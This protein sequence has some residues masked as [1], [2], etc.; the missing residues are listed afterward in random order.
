MEYDVIISSKGQFILP[1]EIR[2]KFRLGT[3][4]KVKIIVDGD[5]IILKP[6]TI[7]D[8]LK[9]LMSDIAKDGRLVTEQTIKEYQAQLNY[10]LERMVAEA[11]QEY[12]AKEYV[13]L[14]DLKR[15]E[16]NV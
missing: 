16:G 2:D 11:E 15:E 9:D 13:T 1:K 3:G 7:S 5:E 4:S 10:A 6:R 12:T 8:E 14:A